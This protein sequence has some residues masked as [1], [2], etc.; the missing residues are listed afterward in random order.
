MTS[1]LVRARAR[2]LPAR[3]SSSTTT[4]RPRS[5]RSSIGRD[6]RA[7]PGCAGRPAVNT[8]LR[9]DRRAARSAVHLCL[10]RGVRR[11]LE[12][13]GRRREGDSRRLVPH[14]R[15]RPSRRGRR[16]L[17]RR[18]RRRHD[19]L[20]RRE[21]PSARGRGRAR[22]AIPAC[23]RW[24]SSA[25]RTTASGTG[26]RRRR[27][28]ATAEELDAHCLA[29]RSPA[30]SVR[31]STVSST[32]LPEEPVGEDPAPAAPR[33]GGEA[34]DRYTRLARRAATR[35]AASRRSRWTSRRS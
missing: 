34:R 10:G 31:A 27:R 24:R 17:D 28:H 9:L 2:G 26:R 20:R 18:P 12:P 1:T 6:Q 23:A 21:H 7:K 4:A 22:R 3:R 29:S 32:S 14:G 16:P 15:H 19:R 30:S 25:R 33:R 5:T 13:A 11:L 35:R 8:R